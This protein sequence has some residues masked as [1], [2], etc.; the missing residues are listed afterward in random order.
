MLQ[1]QWR[2]SRSRWPDLRGY[3]GVWGEEVV[4]RTDARAEKKNVSTAARAAGVYTQAGRQAETV[5][6]ARDQRSR[7]T[8]GGSLGARTDLR[9][10]PAAGTV[11]LSGRPQRVGRREACPQAAQH[12]PWANCRRGFK[13]LL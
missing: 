1:S 13:R 9:G 11:R 8:D 10:R 12:W 4:G 5:R 7:S 2:S 6:S 3:R